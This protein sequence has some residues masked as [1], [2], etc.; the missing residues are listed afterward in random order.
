MNNK[1]AEFWGCVSVVFSFLLFGLVL[2]HFSPSPLPWHVALIDIIGLTG[3]GILHFYYAR[4]QGISQM[5]KG[6][7]AFVK[8]Y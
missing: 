2:N 3:S 8:Y 4:N 6:H 1:K 7:R 5:K